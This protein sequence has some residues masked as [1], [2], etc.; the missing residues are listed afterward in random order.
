MVAHVR[1]WGLVKPTDCTAVAADFSAVGCLFF[2]QCFGDIRNPKYEKKKHFMTS[3]QARS[4]HEHL[5]LSDKET[6]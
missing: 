3:L 5:I 6:L 2:S 1:V 4:I